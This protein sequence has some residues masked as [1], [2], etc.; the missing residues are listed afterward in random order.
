MDIS[1]L[2][3]PYYGNDISIFLQVLITIL[4][5]FLILNYLSS[6][7]LIAKDMQAFEAQKLTPKLKAK[8]CR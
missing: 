6:E 5:F 7:A 3:N 2:K 4:Y 8:V 1:A